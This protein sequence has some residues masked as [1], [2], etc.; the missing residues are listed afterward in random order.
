MNIDVCEEIWNNY[1]LMAEVTGMKR[2]SGIKLDYAN[3][4]PD[5][6]KK[7]GEAGQEVYSLYKAFYKRYDNYGAVRN[8][9]IRAF[10][11]E[12][13]F[14][15][16]SV[17][18]EDL[19]E[20]LQNAFGTDAE[21]RVEEITS[22]G[23]N[24]MQKEAVKNALVQPV[25][26]IQGPPGTGKTKMILYFLAALTELDRLTMEKDPNA[27]PHSV[28]I[29]SC[30]GEA[31]RNI[32]DKLK[33][34]DKLKGYD[35]SKVLEKCA[36]LGRQQFR[37]EWSA[38]DDNY[39]YLDE[40]SEKKY[41]FKPQML[42]KYPFFTS[43]IHSL[44][45]NFGEKR[46]FDYV[47]IDEC[48]QVSLS[49]GLIAMCQAK[50]LIVVG[51]DMQ[52][53]AIVSAGV[54]ESFKALR[55]KLSDKTDPELENCME[56]NK[57]FLTACQLAFPDAPKIMLN[58]HFR[59]HPSIAGFCNEYVYGGEL[60]IMTETPA[61]KNELRID[62]T[63]YDGE[64]MEYYYKEQ[65]LT[66]TE[67]R[68]KEY[69]TDG[70][71][72]FPDR[73]KDDLPSQ[74]CNFRQIR[75]FMEEMYPALKERIKKAKENDE[76][77]P[78]VCVLAPF[79]VH[80][81]VLKDILNK[82]KELTELLGG[83][84][85][86]AKDENSDH[87]A[88]NEDGDEKNMQSLSIH[89]AQGRGYDIV[90]LMTVED[91]HT[92][93][94]T[95][96]GQSMRIINVAVSRAKEELHVITSSIWIPKYIRMDKRIGADGGICVPMPVCIETDFPD[97]NAESSYYSS[98]KDGKIL[99]EDL[100][101]G[102]LCKWVYKWYE[103]P[104]KEIP[105][106]FGF[107]K[108]KHDSVLDCY[109]SAAM[110]ENDRPFDDPVYNQ[111]NTHH[112]RILKETLESEFAPDTVTITPLSRAGQLGSKLL[113]KFKDDCGSENFTVSDSNRKF[114]V[115][116]FESCLDRNDFL[117]VCGENSMIK[118]IV[119]I[120]SAD[121][122]NACRKEYAFQKALEKH[123]HDSD[124]KEGII[125]VQIPTDGS[126]KDEIS[127][128]RSAVAEGGK[129]CVI[130]KSSKDP[131]TAALNAF[132]KK[133][134]EDVKELIKDGLDKEKINA[135]DFDY[136][137]P[138]NV[139]YGGKYR[140]EFYFCRYGTAYAFEYALM[141]D[142]VFRTALTANFKILSLGCGS[143][144]DGFAAAY[145]K[146][147]CGREITLDYHGVD[148][149]KWQLDLRETVGGNFGSCDI[150]VLSGGILEYF[151]N[152]KLLGSNVL[153]FPKIVNEL[154]PELRQQLIGAVRGKLNPETDEYFF[155]F[156]HS[157][158]NCM[159]FLDDA[160]KNKKAFVEKIAS[161]KYDHRHDVVFADELV[162]SFMSGCED[163][164]TVSGN[165]L[166]EKKLT[167][168]DEVWKNA[169]KAGLE[170]HKPLMNDRRSYC[171]FNLEN[172]ESTISGKIEELNADFCDSE[173][174]TEMFGIVKQL[175][176]FKH[177]NHCGEGKD[178][179]NRI[180]GVGPIAHFQ[181]LHL[182]KKTKE[183]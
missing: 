153:F 110:I 117:L 65:G 104:G 76:K 91:D 66:L 78:S 96:W 2:G 92:V 90:Y 75:I 33:D 23:L 52:L 19:T 1:V 47:I 125:Y 69:E 137:D 70:R 14:T 134:L 34:F 145:A 79:R 58:Q 6:M 18:K 9:L 82:D 81:E 113:A 127:K 42:S 168:P 3:I 95:P 151:E 60:K 155:C 146:A 11:R 105:E 161:D 30:N 171:N 126:C 98:D 169:F 44:A 122:R 71:F 77:I 35:F 111:M 7:I 64:Y 55:D 100:F 124:I 40:N 68:R 94:R 22:A 132:T 88:K 181:I 162:S 21:K 53:Q 46:M 20:A 136:S 89:K 133:C 142:L 166:S 51:D 99:K 50:H 61:N 165:I 57:S 173:T 37:K 39:I 84:V 85:E 174:D 128:I 139:G 32:I 83:G 140:Q 36:V 17:K 103:E 164:Y 144:V 48:S 178:F 31:I 25:T 56:E 72:Y 12:D 102:R 179:H 54:A 74:R 154:K 29:V 170:K 8:D 156:S 107:R 120:L 101:V 176:S 41:Y 138:E 175:N 67:T 180:V 172:A 16:A 80:L 87:K 108:A 118:A 45:S 147:H 143:C 86:I 28:A 10:F 183:G 160:K 163:N 141:Y 148:I 49:L 63:W 119:H 130:L 13:G 182:K 15:V 106:G 4:T 5:D 177:E 62:I 157:P 123:I 159:K 167:Q 27:V 43:T 121:Y 26:K 24:A 135:L 158:A 73:D 109:Y 112:L 59:C 116:D 114:T 129:N 115:S 150:E 149:E 152:M 38:K 131:F 97:K 93:E